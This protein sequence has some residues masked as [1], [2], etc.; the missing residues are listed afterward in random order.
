LRRIG[1]LRKL[2]GRHPMTDKTV[3]EIEIIASSMDAIKE[4]LDVSGEMREG[5]EKEL[6]NGATLTVSEVSKS[7]GFDATTVMLTAVVSVM[8]ST[9]SAV[10]TE[11]LKSRLF[12]KEDAKEPKK[13]ITIIVDGKKI[14][15]DGI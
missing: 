11:W 14:E 10:L 12:K 6:A 2:S 7:S 13:G 3:H 9:S 5:S 4:L 1:T 15:F 8:V